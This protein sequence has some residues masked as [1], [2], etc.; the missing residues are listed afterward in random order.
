LSDKTLDFFFVWVWFVG[1][2]QGIFLEVLDF[3]LAEWALVNVELIEEYSGRRRCVDGRGVLWR[4]VGWKWGGNRQGE[5][6]G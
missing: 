2:G 6:V 5:G 1:W 3:F 4:G